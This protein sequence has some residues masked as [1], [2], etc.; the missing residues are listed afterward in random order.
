MILGGEAYAVHGIKAG[1]IG[2]KTGKAPRIHCG[3]DFTAQQEKEKNNNRLRILA[4][5]LAKLREMMAAPEGTAEQRA[6]MEELLRRLEA[7]QQQ[8]AAKV[9]DLLG[10]INTDE[11]AAVEVPGEIVAGTLIEICQ[12][13]LYVTEPLRKVR[14]RLDKDTGKVI[15]EAL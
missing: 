12:V 6:K 2:K 4:A 7:E 3:I 10:R 5:K 11:N 1:G 8:A 14:V 9:S 13:A 15:S